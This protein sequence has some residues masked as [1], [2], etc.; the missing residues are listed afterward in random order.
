M[1]TEKDAVLMVASAPTGIVSNRSD[2]VVSV[3]AVAAA[4]TSHCQFTRYQA[5]PSLAIAQFRVPAS[6]RL[7]N[8]FTTLVVFGVVVWWMNVT[9]FVASIL[10]EPV[11]VAM[12]NIRAMP[13][14]G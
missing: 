7:I 6:G 3:A 14:C 8:S 12:R 11:K 2:A 5:V 10:Q 13:G 9:T 4:R 1:L